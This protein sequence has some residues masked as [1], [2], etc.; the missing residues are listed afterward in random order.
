LPSMMAIVLNG[1][2]LISSRYASKWLCSSFITDKHNYL[3]GPTSS[4]Y[5]CNFYCSNTFSYALGIT[6]FFLGWSV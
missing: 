6:R 2:Q 3:P 4:L 5:K 1:C